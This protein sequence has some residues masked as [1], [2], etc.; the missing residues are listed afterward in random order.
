[1]TM[2][3]CGNEDLLSDKYYR[4]GIIGRRNSRLI[5]RVMAY[6]MA[7][8]FVERDYVVVSGLAHGIDIMAHMG[9]IEKTIAVVDNIEN[10][11]P[12]ENFAIY[13]DIIWGYNGLAISP[14]EKPKYDPKRFLERDHM[15]VDICHEIRVP[16]V[17]PM[18]THSGT[19]FTMNYAVK[20]GKDV[21]IWRHG[22]WQDSYTK[23]GYKVFD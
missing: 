1:M 18:D 14:Y 20:Q 10:P 15:L 4:V 8:G 9:G 23:F 21:Y 6:N 22:G 7:K 3:K 2:Y 17:S 11:Y 12:K 5:N 13:D 16:E 19:I